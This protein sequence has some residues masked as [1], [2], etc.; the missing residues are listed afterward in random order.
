MDACLKSP[1]LAR[2]LVSLCVLFEHAQ[3]MSYGNRMVDTAKY[4]NWNSD[5]KNLFDGLEKL[6][7]RFTGSGFV[8]IY[9]FAMIFS[10][11]GLLVYLA[12]M[13]QI[14]H[15]NKGPGLGW[16][17]I[18]LID[19]VIF[20][21]GFVPMMAVLSEVQYCTDSGDLMDYTSITCWDTKQMAMT[22]FGFFG[23]SCA[24]IVSGV[25][26]PILKSERKGVESRFIDEVYFPGMFKLLE[27][28]IINIFAAVHHAYL[29]IVACLVLIVYLGVYQCYR[30]PFIAAI[31][32]SVLWG[33]L[34]VFCCAQE[35]TANT[36][37]GSSLLAGWVP[38]MAVGYA[39]MWGVWLLWRRNTNK[40]ALEK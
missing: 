31:K 14:H 18:A 26:C 35:M 34:W 28:G 22:I 39:C 5:S 16:V 3:V 29:G 19:N 7:L 21:L 33:Q 12:L 23:A 2:I 25:V 13:P 32:M 6:A 38:F 24:L 40:M 10:V 27:V 9:T 36:D 30:D 20:G 8:V 1:W 17:A 4:S 15:W 37:T 11:L